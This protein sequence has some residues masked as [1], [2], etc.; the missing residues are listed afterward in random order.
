MVP[1]VTWDCWKQIVY[2]TTPEPS[3]GR[4]LK[5]VVDDAM[6]NEVI[7]SNEKDGNTRTIVWY[8]LDEQFK[9]HFVM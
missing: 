5:D 2:E 3:M 1:N 4:P 6:V 7:I 8:I 9:F